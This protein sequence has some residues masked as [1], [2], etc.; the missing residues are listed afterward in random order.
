MC[1]VIMCR[2][3]R[4]E[5][6]YE[7]ESMGLHLY[8]LEELA[9]FLFEN[10]YMVDRRMLGQ[11]LFRWIAE[12]VGDEELAHKLERGAESGIGLPNL[13]L[14]ILREVDY[15]SKEELELLLERMKKLATYQEQ[16]R[17]KLRADEYFINGNY[18]AAINEYQKILDIRQSD[19][20]GV[21]FY[22][23]VW[24]N[25]GDCYCRLFLFYKASKAFRTSYQYRKDPEVLASYVYSLKFCLSEEDFEEAME[26][27]NIR[28][29]QLASM[30]ERLERLEGEAGEHIKADTNPEESLWALK[31]EYHRNV[32][33]S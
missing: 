12:E 30:I 20:L 16:E 15:Y 27:Q 7:I 25:L 13:I 33:F 1:A 3:K 22:A 29:E 23:H 11:R 31:Q 10:V 9:Y 5:V 8:S 28:G 2:R 21:D 14:A 18:Q 24:N 4:A 6:P 26:L 32:R 17:L 19:R